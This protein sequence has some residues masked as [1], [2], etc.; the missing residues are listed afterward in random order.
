MFDEGEKR[1]ADL[2]YTFCPVPHQKA[3]LHIFI[4]H[5]CQHPLFPMQDGTQ[6][7][8][9]ICRNAMFKMYGFCH[10]RGLRGV[11]GYFWTAWYAPRRWKLWAQSTSPYISCLQTTM[12][13]ENFWQQLKHNFLHNHVLPRLDHL[14]WILITTALFQ[15][16]YL[17]HAQILA[18]GHQLGRSKVLMPFQKHFK[19]D[20]MALAKL[21]ISVNAD[22]KYI[23]WIN[24]WTCTCKQQ[25]FQSCHLCKHLVQG[26]ATPPACFWTK[27]I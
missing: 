25:K 6:T 23:T 11:W 8:E 4:K 22:C 27:V 5:F 26:V 13:V 10:K 9:D 15:P 3:L 14:V 19:A 2:G 20:W 17:A 7:A 24:L 16:T 12:N 1:S 21:P 18:D